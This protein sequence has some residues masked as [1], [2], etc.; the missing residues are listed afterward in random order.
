MPQVWNPPAETADQ[1][2]AVP[3]CTATVR[4]C[5]VPSPNLPELLK[6]QHHSDPVE[7]DADV[8]WI[9][10]VWTCPADTAIHAEPPGATTVGTVR[11]EVSLT[12][13]CPSRFR[14]QQYS[15]P[16]VRVAHEWYEPAVT[17]TQSSSD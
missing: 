10:Q 7:A 8:P 9:P 13:S 6:P 11:T 1:S 14:P 5:V 2:V 3:T 12:P 15:A 16:D 4:V 17:C